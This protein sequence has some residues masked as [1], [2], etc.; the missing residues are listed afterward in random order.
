[1]SKLLILIALSISSIV[2]SQK[3]E[4]SLAYRIGIDIGDKKE[5]NSVLNTQ[6]DQ[7]ITLQFKYRIWNKA[8]LY[9][10]FGYDNSAT[11]YTILEDFFGKP[12]KHDPFNVVKFNR[13]GIQLGLLKRFEIKKFSIDLGLN[14]STRHMVHKNFTSTAEG[15]LNEPAPIY[16]KL[17]VETLPRYRNLGLDFNL[18]VNYNLFKSFCLSAEISHTRGHYM[19]YSSE[20][21]LIDHN[22]LMQSSNS[23]VY[24]ESNNFLHFNLG[25][26]YQL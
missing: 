4:L 3:H 2:Y 5:N 18:N 23:K 24:F 8:K 6:F 21:I 25:C 20:A 13:H 11:K 14:A 9:F 19:K 17:N 16:R 15:G 7:G 22:G 1:M 10:L 12:E 26:T